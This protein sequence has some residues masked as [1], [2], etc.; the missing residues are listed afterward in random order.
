[1]VS[2]PPT[3]KVLIQGIIKMA[4]N[5]VYIGNKANYDFIL[6]GKSMGN[7][8]YKPPKMENLLAFFESST[9][10][11]VDNLEDFVLFTENDDFMYAIFEEKGIRIDLINNKE[12]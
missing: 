4:N 1:M 9:G 3:L 5:R 12:K 8:I 11:I 6:F 7:G 10:Y 2:I